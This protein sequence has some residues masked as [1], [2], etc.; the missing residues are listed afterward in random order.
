MMDH[1]VVWTGLHTGRRNLVE[2]DA[3]RWHGFWG[4]HL[5]IKELP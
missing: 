1:F 5:F 2:L 3:L 4:F